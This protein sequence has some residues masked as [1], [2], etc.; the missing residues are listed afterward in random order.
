MIG[1]VRE[2]FRWPQPIP[3]VAHMRDELGLN[4]QQQEIID[5]LRSAN[6]PLDVDSGE[7]AD[8]IG[9][10]RKRVDKL[11]GSMCYALMRELFRLALIGFEAEKARSVPNR[12][13]C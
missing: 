6:C 2:Y 7:I 9:V 8:H 3:F 12:D 4:L 1:R 13:R 11:I 5:Y 10:T